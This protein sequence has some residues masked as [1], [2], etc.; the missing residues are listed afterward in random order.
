MAIRLLIIFSYHFFYLLSPTFFKGDALRFFPI[1][2][3]GD[4]FLAGT[5]FWAFGLAE[6]TFFFGEMLPVFL[7]LATFFWI[8]ALS[9]YFLASGLG[10]LVIA[11]VFFSIFF[12]GLVTEEGFEDLTGV[13]YFFIGEIF[14]LDVLTFLAAVYIFS[15]SFL[16]AFAS[17]FF[18]LSAT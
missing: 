2:V 10:A 3:L 1:T 14:E 15:D 7:G 12:T 13:A 6:T 5:F 18:G 4:V 16:S 11:L 8:F 17:R 9:N